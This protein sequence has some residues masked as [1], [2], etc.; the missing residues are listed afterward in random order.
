MQLRVKDVSQLL[1]VPE[2]TLRRWVREGRVPCQKMHDDYRFH[3]AELLEWANAAGIGLN[4]APAAAPSLEEEPLPSLAGA[5]AAGGIIP[6]VAGRDKAEVLT[7]VVA[8]LPLP[9]EVDRE[10]L[11]QVLLAREALGSTAVGEGI[12]I[13]HA[14]H[15]MVLPLTQPLLCLAY[16]ERPVDFS[17]P[18]G[19]A[20]GI[21]FTLASTTVRTH[22]HLLS[23]LALALR[24]PAF[25]AAVTGRAGL[26]AVLAA[27]GQ[28][29]AAH[30]A[31]PAEPPKP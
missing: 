8:Q 14:R 15:P 5:L 4:P 10:W 13:P 22:L 28:V 9:P 25:R 19:Q 12:A 30:G 7:R 29:D 1:Q 18:D 16:L 20:V 31:V 23:R 21:L 11:G 6:Q 2:K 3:R 27:A 26:T 24:D 17:A